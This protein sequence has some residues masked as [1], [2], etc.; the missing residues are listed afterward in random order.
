[1]S[2]KSNYLKD[3]VINHLLRTASLPKPSGVYVALYTA[4]PGPGD[5]G[6]EVSGGGYARVQVGPSNAAWN[7]PAGT[8]VTANTSDIVFPTPSADLGLATHFALK[9]ALTGGAQIYSNA[10]APPRTLS[11]GV[12]VRFPAGSLTVSEQ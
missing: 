7:D 6:T 8:G 1:M 10:L 2:D 9:D 12:S 11:N 4:D 3:G 5:G